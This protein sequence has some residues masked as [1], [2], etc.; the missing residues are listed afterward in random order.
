MIGFRSER[1]FLTM[2]NVFMSNTE[3]AAQMAALAD[4]RR[5]ALFGYLASGGTGVLP[6]RLMVAFDEAAIAQRISVATPRVYTISAT[7]AYGAATRT[8]TSVIDF[9]Q[10]GRL[11][12]WREY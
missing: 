7:G 12:Y 11:L 4:P 6:S 8:I 1:D 5:A 3:Y 9:T 10:D 2:L